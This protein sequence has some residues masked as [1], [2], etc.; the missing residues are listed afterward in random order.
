VTSVNKVP[1]LGDLPVLGMLFT[2]RTMDGVSPNPTLQQDLLI[3]LTV[4][5]EKELGES[6]VASTPVE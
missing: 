1:I 3:F 4:K 6:S 5:L 2:N